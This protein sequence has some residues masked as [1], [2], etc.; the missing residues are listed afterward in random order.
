MIAIIYYANR[1]GIFNLPPETNEKLIKVIKLI[2]Q[3]LTNINRKAPDSL[4]ITDAL[5]EIRKDPKKLISIKIKDI[6][7]NNIK[8]KMDKSENERFDLQ[9]PNLTNL[10]HNIFREKKKVDQFV[11]GQNLK[12]SL[13]D[14]LKK[15]SNQI[16][17]PNNE[18]DYLSEILEEYF[19]Q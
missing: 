3:K 7:N 17:D 19:D 5:R 4:N 13:V 12:D 11:P 8:I 15:I 14:D 2:I 1:V 16:A 6:V 18:N 10:V 9:I